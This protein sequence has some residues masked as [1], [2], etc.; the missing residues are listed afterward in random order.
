MHLVLQCP[1]PTPTQNQGTT[2]LHTEDLTQEKL[3]CKVGAGVASAEN[4]LGLMD[5]FLLNMFS[6]DLLYTCTALI[7]LP[8]LERTPV[9]MDAWRP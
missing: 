9:I 5:S 3:V 6:H 1:G 7:S 4:C 8:L 2:L